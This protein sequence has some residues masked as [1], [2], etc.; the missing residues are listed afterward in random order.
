[1][2]YKGHKNDM[3]DIKSVRGEA[4]PKH[5]TGIAPKYDFSRMKIDETWEI[6]FEDRSVARA[7]AY[8]FSYK[9]EGAG[10]K[11]ESWTAPG[12]D[13]KNKKRFFMKRIA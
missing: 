3:T 10:F 11:F 4:K 8:G 1:M 13:D 5:G 12:S 7:N 2:Q 6:P 9:I